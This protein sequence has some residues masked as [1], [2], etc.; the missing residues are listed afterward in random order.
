MMS[1]D[2]ERGDFA[3][4][5][6]GGGEWEGCGVWTEMS[7]LGK[8]GTG[9]AAGGLI[10]FVEGETEWIR[11]GRVPHVVVLLLDKTMRWSGWRRLESPFT[12]LRDLVDSE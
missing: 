5:R 2:L 8:G 7:G 3:R 11:L 12:G 1:L 9:R 6:T 4:G 10:A